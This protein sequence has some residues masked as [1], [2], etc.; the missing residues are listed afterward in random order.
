MCEFIAAATQPAAQGMEK[1]ACGY[2][3]LPAG[4]EACEFNSYAIVYDADEM[5]EYVDAD[6]RMRAALAAQANGEA[7]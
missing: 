1:S 5:R 4:S 6:R 2:P 3:E 7:A